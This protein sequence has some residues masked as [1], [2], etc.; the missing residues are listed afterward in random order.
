MDYESEILRD[1]YLLFHY[2][3]AEEI[4]NG[5]GFD[6]A[7]LP[8][9]CLEFPVATADMA[10]GGAMVG[11]VLDL[12]CAVGRSTFELT[13][14]AEEV[15]GIDYSASFIDCA[16]RIRNGETV[17][18]HRYAEMH[19]REL[20]QVS[21]DPGWRME[22]ADFRTGDA[23][24][25][26]PG[27]GSFDLVH[28]ANLLCRLP[29]PAWFLDSLPALVRP[30][31]KLLLA[32]PASWMENYTPRDRQP[33]GTTLDFI[34][35]RIGNAFTLESVVEVPFLIR[36]HRRKFQLSTS[37]TSLWVRSVESSRDPGF[38]G[39]SRIG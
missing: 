34:S 26:D 7:G 38:P 25:L 4:L 11:R 18:Y 22:L 32:T 14:F 8:P 16:R 24:N 9:R 6:A 19:Q 29:D 23:M 31:G 17:A 5:T 28:A 30:G 27:L 10:T 15:V 3:S 39:S 33:H 21:P 37:Q 35:A 12:G 2:G 13:R 1:W 20:L 36:E